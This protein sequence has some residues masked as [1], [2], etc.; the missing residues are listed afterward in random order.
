MS[1]T[2]KRNVAVAVAPVR[3]TVV[4]KEFDELM[5][6]EPATMLQFVD[7]RGELPVCTKPFMVKD[8]VAP[9]VHLDWSGPASET[10]PSRKL[11]WTGVTKSLI[12]AVADCEVLVFMRIVLTPMLRHGSKPETS[13]VKSTAASANRF[14]A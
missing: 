8:V 2:D 7:V 13:A 14:A 6:A 11:T 4:D 12:A 5:L 9:S 1:V 3:T 10:G